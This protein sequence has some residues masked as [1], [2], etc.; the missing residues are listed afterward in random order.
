[1]LVDLK[2]E[3]IIEL[4]TEFHDYSEAGREYERTLEQLNQMKT[5]YF[6]AKSKVVP[7]SHAVFDSLYFLEEPKLPKKPLPLSANIRES[8]LLRRFR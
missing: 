2:E 6:L 5:E 4:S 3:K 8:R 7:A 1:M